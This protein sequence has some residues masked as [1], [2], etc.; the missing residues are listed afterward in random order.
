M[1]ADLQ[2]SFTVVFSK[3]FATKLMPHCSS[4]LICVAALPCEMLKNKIG[5]IMLHLTQ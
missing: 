3:N 4:H 2:N 5:E 1:L